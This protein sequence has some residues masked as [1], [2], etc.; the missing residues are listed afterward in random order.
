M[1]QQ[2]QT[3]NCDDSCI[4]SECSQQFCHDGESNGTKLIACEDCGR[5]YCLAHLAEAELSIFL[6]LDC[7]LEDALKAPIS[8]ERAWELFDQFK[9]PFEF[10]DSWGIGAAAGLKARMTSHSGIIHEGGSI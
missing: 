4:G 9:Q 8:T 10:T 6:C 1:P 3:K 2:S 5:K 7:Q